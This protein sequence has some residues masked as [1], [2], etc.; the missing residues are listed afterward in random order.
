MKFIA[1]PLPG[2]VLIQPRFSSDDRG[3]FVKNFSRDLFLKNGIDFT[4]REEFYSVS[5]SG[6]LRGMHFQAPPADYGK[7]VHCIRGRF[8]DAVLDIRA[9]SPTYGQVWSGEFDDVRHEALYLP[10]GFAHGF[11]ALEPETIVSYSVSH[12]H[13]PALDRG[14]RWD[15]FGHKWPAA[16][17]VVS[18]RDRGLPAFGEFSTPFSYS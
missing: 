16:D 11:Y 10:P 6:V 5:H 7:L 1:L 13:D 12:V 15:S 4:P 17:P 3:S 8:H 2:L 9:G 14:I 18:T